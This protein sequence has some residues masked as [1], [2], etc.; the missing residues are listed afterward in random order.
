VKKGKE[1]VAH[2]LERTLSREPIVVWTKFEF[3]IDEKKF[4]FLSNNN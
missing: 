2:I 4:S 1:L 3:I